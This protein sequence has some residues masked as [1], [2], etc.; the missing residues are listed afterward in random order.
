LAILISKFIDKNK[1]GKKQL[2]KIIT[3]NP[4]N[5]D[6]ILDIVIKFRPEKYNPI[7][8]I[9]SNINC[10]NVSCFIIG[11]NYKL[12]IVKVVFVRF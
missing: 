4:S 10:F 11:G 6:F 12:I 2:K 5:K 9:V 8:E 1:K 3:F 7:E